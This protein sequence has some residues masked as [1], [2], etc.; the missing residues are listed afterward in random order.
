MKAEIRACQIGGGGLSL[1]AGR[2]NGTTNAA[3]NVRLVGDVDGQLKVIVGLSGGDRRLI[4]GGASARK[5]GSARDDGEKRRTCNANSGPG[6]KELGLSGFQSFIGDGD[7]ILES[8][9][10]R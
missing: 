5:R 3:P 10:L 7:L 2:F 9:E 8:V 1:R 4:L 6:L